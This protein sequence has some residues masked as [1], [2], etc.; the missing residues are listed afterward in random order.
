MILST[1]GP[2][3][4]LGQQDWTYT[5][6]LSKWCYDQAASR[7][8]SLNPSH[9]ISGCAIGWDQIAAIAAIRHGTPLELAIPFDGFDRDWPA[10]CKE[11]HQKLLRRATKVTVVGT[12]YSAII[13]QRRN[14][15]M[16]DSS[17]KLLALYDGISSGGTKNCYDYAVKVGKPIIRIDPRTY[18]KSK[19]R[20]NCRNC[21]AGT[22]HRNCS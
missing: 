11:I 6:N 22:P 20:N 7:I 14:I 4:I 2:R 1:T 10:P 13:Y 9:F 17:D 8:R 16:V 5:S 15:Y 21:D 18:S 19:P 3:K 12:S